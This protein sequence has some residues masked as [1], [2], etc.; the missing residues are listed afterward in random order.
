MALVG[1]V[2]KLQHVLK[3]AA[4]ASC[5]KTQRH[6]GIVDNFRLAY[7]RCAKIAAKC[8]SILLKIPAPLVLAIPPRRRIPR[9]H[10]LF[11]VHQPRPRGPLKTVATDPA[12]TAPIAAPAAMPRVVIA[13]HALNVTI[14][15]VPPAMGVLSKVVHPAMTATAVV[16]LPHV[17][18]VPDLTAMSAPLKAANAASAV[19]TVAS[20]LT[21][22]RVMVIAVAIVLKIVTLVTVHVR[23][24]L[25]V[26]TKV[27]QSAPK[28][29]SAASSVRVTTAL[30]VAV[31]LVTVHVRPVLAVLTKVAQSAPKVASAASSVR[32]MTDVM[33]VLKAAAILVIVHKTVAMVALSVPKV[34]S[35]VNSVRVTANAATIS[36]AT[37][38]V[39]AV[40]ALKAA[41]MSALK[42]VTLA[43]VHRTVVLVTVLKAVPLTAA[44]VVVTAAMTSAVVSAA[45]TVAMSVVA[46]LK[47]AISPARLFLKRPAAQRLVS[48]LTVPPRMVR[49]A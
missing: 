28:V 32:V 19:V 26:L 45:T 20:D 39:V 3:Q 27:V 9:R 47:S 35:A 5:P 1:A 13:A 12:A 16:A 15:H 4:L 30:K 40:T 22:S 24:V 6:A 46:S 38:S 17:M 36:P 43:I 34:V 42:V 18:I 21:A 11:C 7:A 44:T 14:V 10:A 8:Q 2:R 29:A 25:V 48:A 49:T 23:P 33:T 41:V 37:L 31:I